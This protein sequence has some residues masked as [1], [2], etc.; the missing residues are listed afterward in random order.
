MIII[1]VDFNFRKAVIFIIKINR[2]YSKEK[3]YNS[4][5]LLLNLFRVRGIN[6]MKVASLRK[7]LHE[8]KPGKVDLKTI[9]QLRKKL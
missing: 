6:L 5:L 7:L 4:L 3:K 2:Y 1:F 8:K 9:S